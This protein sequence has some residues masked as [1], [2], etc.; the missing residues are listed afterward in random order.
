MMEVID[1]QIFVY[2]VLKLM[3][4]LY[5]DINFNRTM[6]GRQTSRMSSVL[7]VCL[8]VVLCLTS[9]QACSPVSEPP[10]LV[11]RVHMADVIIHGIVSTYMEFLFSKFTTRSDLTDPEFC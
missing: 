1:W 9:V 6:A 7:S 8:W 11:Q 3:H 4:Y 10:P 5:P 2:K